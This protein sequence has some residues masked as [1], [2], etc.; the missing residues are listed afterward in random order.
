MRSVFEAEALW[1]DVATDQECELIVRNSHSK[2]MF[3]AFHLNQARFPDLQFARFGMHANLRDPQIRTLMQAPN[4]EAADTVVLSFRYS[5]KT[6]GR[7]PGLIEALQAKGKRVVLMLST[8]E[9]QAIDARPVFGWFVQDSGQAFDADRLNALAW[10]SRDLS[11]IPDLNAQLRR[12]AQA[13]GIS[14]LDKADFICAAKAQSC[15]MVS[16]TGHKVFYDYG[17]FTLEGAQ[18]FGAKIATSGWFDSRA[19]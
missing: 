9:F 10:E 17:H 2:D 11:E 15:D 6:M 18:H 13:A 19:P 1:F 12:I 14:V 3:N 4:L 5:P 7:L 16:D 8:V